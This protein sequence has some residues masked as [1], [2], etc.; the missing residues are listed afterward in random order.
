MS[1]NSFWFSAIFLWL[2]NMA[3]MWAFGVILLLPYQSIPIRII[4]SA[5]AV[6]NIGAFIG[7][8]LQGYGIGIIVKASGGYF[9]AFVVMAVF[10]LLHG[11][12]PFLLDGKNPNAEAAAGKS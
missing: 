7:G 9:V 5:F 4:G 10:L 3:I 8:I 1:V 6:I 12:V 11:L 2:S